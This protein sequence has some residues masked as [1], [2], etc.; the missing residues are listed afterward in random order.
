MISFTTDPYQP[1]EAI[2]FKTWAVLRRL[3]HT[4]HIIMILTKSDLARRDFDLMKHDNVWLGCTITALTKINDEP[5][6][7]PN[8]KRIAMLRDAHDL[9]INTFMSIEPILPNITNPVEIIKHTHPFIDY[10]IIGRLDYET[11]Y[12][13]PKIPK[14]YYQKYIDECLYTLLKLK[15]MFHFKKQLIENP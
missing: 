7:P 11:K 9:G 4:K 5:Y 14:G 1:K 6:A 8:D 10:Y 2:E 3:V 13:Y 12:G 15:K